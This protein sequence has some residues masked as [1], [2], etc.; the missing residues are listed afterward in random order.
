MQRDP[1]FAHPAQGF[2]LG[3]VV[4]IVLHG[5][6][7]TAMLTIDPARF[8]A[9]KPIEIDVTELPPPEVKPVPPA[10]PPPKVEPRP[11]VAIRPIRAPREAPPPPPA[12]PPPSAEPPPKPDEPP[13]IFGTSLSSTVSGPSSV[14]VPVGSTLTAAPTQHAPAARAGNGDGDGFKPVADIYISKFAEKIFVP[15]GEEFYPT[16]AKRMGI[17]G[18]VKLK[19]GIDENGNIV[20]VKVLTVAGHGF[21]E[22][23]SKALWRAKFKPAVS[24]DGRAVPSNL[25]YVYRFETQ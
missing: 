2:W 9:E 25:M 4:A 16:E 21:D 22:A 5:G 6:I 7:A 11:R 3:A 13:P 15:D 17:E 24:S 1:T 18:V 23:A 10:P 8:R 19:I 20:R 12:A 14:S